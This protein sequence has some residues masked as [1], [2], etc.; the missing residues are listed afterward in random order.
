MVICEPFEKA[1][2]TERNARGAERPGL[3]AFTECL[4]HHEEVLPTR[5][6]ESS[7]AP[8]APIRARRARPPRRG[9]VN[10]RSAPPNTTQNKNALQV[11][12]GPVRFR[13]DR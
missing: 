9:D 3:C 4:L 5:P 6:D 10:V 7:P 1:F 11:R 13:P 2:T 8:A 12:L